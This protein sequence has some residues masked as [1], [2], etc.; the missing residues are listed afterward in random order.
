MNANHFTDELRLAAVVLINGAI[1]DALL[2]WL[3]TQYV[4]LTATGLLGLMQTDSIWAVA[5]TI[6]RFAEQM[7]QKVFDNADAAVYMIP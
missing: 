5:L 1:L 6:L 2:L 4:A 7:F 3:A